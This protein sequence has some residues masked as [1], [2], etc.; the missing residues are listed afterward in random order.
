MIGMHQL[1]S[2]LKATP[3]GIEGI[4]LIGLGALN[5]LLGRLMMIGQEGMLRY[6]NEPID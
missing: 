6:Y 5:V 1:R 2:P 3:I 4:F